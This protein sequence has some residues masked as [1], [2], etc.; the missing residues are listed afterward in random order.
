ML[1][2][3]PVLFFGAFFF[4][5]RAKNLGQTESKKKRERKKDGEGHILLQDVKHP[6]K[7]SEIFKAVEQ[8]QF[9]YFFISILILPSV[10]ELLRCYY[11]CN[12][13][14]RYCMDAT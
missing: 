2:V 6:R 13:T 12:I 1:L 8:P 9:F 4:F 5:W 11:S 3:N 7:C 14:E 10:L